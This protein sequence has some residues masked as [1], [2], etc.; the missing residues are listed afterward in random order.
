MPET[1]PIPA[2]LHHGQR[3]L[4]EPGLSMPTKKETRNN[5]HEAAVI[6]FSYTRLLGP[7]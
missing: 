6:P 1:H 4:Y 5:G 3:Q 7:F 2:L